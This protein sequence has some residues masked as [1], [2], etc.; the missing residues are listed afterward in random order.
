MYLARRAAEAASGGGGE[1]R[2]AAAAAAAELGRLRESLG[3][4]HREKR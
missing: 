2:R 3:G 1:R 4:G